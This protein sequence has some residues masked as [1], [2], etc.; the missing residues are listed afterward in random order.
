[1]SLVVPPIQT[2][3]TWQDRRLQSYDYGFN[4]SIES[5][6]VQITPPVAQDA[7]SGG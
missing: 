5:R 3:A 2:L 4:E 7:R 6:F 1:M